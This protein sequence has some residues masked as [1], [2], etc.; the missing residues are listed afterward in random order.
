MCPIRD[1]YNVIVGVKGEVG[2]WESP[3]FPL[4]YHHYENNTTFLSL[5][6]TSMI[7][8]MIHSWDDQSSDHMT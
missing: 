4:N 8:D 7:H 2:A 3:D 5:F 1:V 6:C